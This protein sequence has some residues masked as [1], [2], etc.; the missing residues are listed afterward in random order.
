MWA[1]IV[2]ASSVPA[3]VAI[4]AVAVV[5]DDDAT[6]AQPLVI[7]AFLTYGVLMIAGT[8]LWARAKGYE[9]AFGFV[10]GLFA[11]L[12]LILLVLLPDATG[13][14]ELT[15]VSS[16]SDASFPCGCG[17]LIRVRF[18]QAGSQTSCDACG[19]VVYVPGL[20]DLKARRERP[21]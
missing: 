12:S 5:L 2:T 9:A 17:H 1:M 14:D 4:I 7:V 20:A 8:T 16:R 15:S 3:L 18:A 21:P 10:L 6:A 13:R 11:P 19:N